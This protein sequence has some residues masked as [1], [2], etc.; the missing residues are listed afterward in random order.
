MSSTALALLGARVFFPGADL[1]AVLCALLSVYTFIHLRMGGWRTRSFPSF[2]L[3]GAMLAAYTVKSNAAGAF[4]RDRFYMLFAACMLAF[5]LDT[6]TR[7]ESQMSTRRKLMI[8][9]WNAPA[10][11]NILGSF[12]LDMTKTRSYIERK[13]AETG[14]K[15]TITHLVIKAAG[16]VLRKTPDVNGRL[17]MGRYYPAETCDIGCLVSLDTDRGPDLANAKICDADSRALQDIAAELRAKAERL[18]AGRDE[19]FNKSKPLMALLPT[20]LLAPVVATVGWLGALGLSIPALGV[21]PHPF[22]TAMV[23]SV[24]M[25][26]LD[27]CFVPHTPFAHVPLII[28]V[29]SISEQPAVS[30]TGTVVSRPSLPL[31]VTV[32]HRFLDGASGAVM[33]RELKKALEDPEAHLEPLSGA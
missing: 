12:N 13:R 7:W 2:L 31:T 14:S 30:P 11:G 24:G 1:K 21:R 18:R 25:L 8:S 3:T 22:G 32:D 26:G 9:S 17:V 28:M 4:N 15:I 6:F 20:P 16:K 10:E 27:M 19:D 5:R 33:A 23:T 29:G